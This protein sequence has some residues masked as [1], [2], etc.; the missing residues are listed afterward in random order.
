MKRAVRNLIRLLASG[1][2]VAGVMMIGLEI[3]GR[4]VD[5]GR[6]HI[7]YWLIGALLLV[8]GI[9]LLWASDRLAEHFTDDFE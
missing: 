1:L 2:I 9:I 4:R 5:T 3:M 8:A 6:T 7:W